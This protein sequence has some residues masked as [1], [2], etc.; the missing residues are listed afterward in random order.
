MRE[1]LYDVVGGE[2]LSLREMLD[3]RPCKEQ[4]RAPKG[5]DPAEA[6]GQWENV[7]HVQR[8]ESGWCS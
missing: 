6:L 4:G 2:G 5:E 8:I 7:C 3:C 1:V